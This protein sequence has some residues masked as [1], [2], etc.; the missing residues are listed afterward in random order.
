MVPSPSL[1]Q[2]EVASRR[3]AVSHAALTGAILQERLPDTEAV[4]SISMWMSFH[5]LRC[6]KFLKSS[7]SQSCLRH[8]VV[9]R[10]RTKVPTSRVGLQDHAVLS[11]TVWLR[12]HLPGLMVTRCVRCNR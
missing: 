12:C 1:A 4:E 3:L 6:E 11:I 5:G 7:G 10:P 8:R 2:T 9:S